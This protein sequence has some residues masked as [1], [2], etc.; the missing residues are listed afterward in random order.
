MTLQEGPA[1]APGHLRVVCGIS[2]SSVYR[3]TSQRSGEVSVLK[4]QM[5]KS[6]KPCFQLQ[7]EPWSQRT[8]KLT[9]VPEATPG[10]FSS[11]LVFSGKASDFQPI[12]SS[13][14]SPALL[15]SSEL[16][17]SCCVLTQLCPDLFRP[18]GRKGSFSLQTASC[19]KHPCGCGARWGE[20]PSARTASPPSGWVGRSW[21]SEVSCVTLSVVEGIISS[22]T[23]GSRLCGGGGALK[24]LLVCSFSCVFLSLPFCRSRWAS[25]PS[26]APW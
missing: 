17:E 5:K 8:Q 2:Q 3:E 7:L 15:P 20:H 25:Q 6:H 12:P 11:A 13:S 4:D 14:S 1:G 24:H 10:K 19:S 21:D 26:P 22:M 16:M 18:L 23:W 9:P